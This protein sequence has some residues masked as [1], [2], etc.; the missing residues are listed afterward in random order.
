MSAGNFDRALAEILRHEG[1]YVFDKRDPGGETNYGITRAT[2]RAHGY[3]GS[4]RSIPMSL[5]ERIYRR[6]YWAAVRGDD[7]PSGVDLAVFDFGVNSGPQ[8]AAEFLQRAIGVDDDGRIGPIT[9]S[10]V[11]AADPAKVIRAICGDRLAWLRTLK[12]WR[13]FGRGWTNRVQDVE[14]TAVSWVAEDAPA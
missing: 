12:T 3:R 8:R 7:L 4:M 10:A 11:A 5:V 9:L 14:R 13:H 2:A 1:G 6:S